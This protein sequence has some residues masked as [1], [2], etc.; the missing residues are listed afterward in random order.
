[1]RDYKIN[2]HSVSFHNGLIS[3]DLL[4]V[5]NIV[6]ILLSNRYGTTARLYQSTNLNA[7][8]RGFKEAQC[9]K[10]R[11]FGH[12]LQSAHACYSSADLAVLLPSEPGSLFVI[13][14]GTNKY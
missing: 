4:T 8:S 7:N 10:L 9:M 6:N 1:M 11:Q 14:D 13:V 3:H 5:A 2:M 12:T